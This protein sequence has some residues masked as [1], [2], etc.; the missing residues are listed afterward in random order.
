MKTIY[1][2]N[3]TLDG[4][5]EAV[6]VLPDYFEELNSDF[7]Y[8]FAPMGSSMPNLY[9]AE[10]VRNNRFKIGGGKPGGEVSWQV[11]GIRKDPYAKAHPIEVEVEK[12]PG[13][14]GKYQHPAEW[15]QPESKGIGYEEP[16]HIQEQ[17]EQLEQRDPVAT[18]KAAIP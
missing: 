16:Q 1:D 8:Q 5:G 9:I 12:S 10:K 14:K 7:R 18:P 11:T 6:V 2:G 4:K 17:K 13:E 15:G 3:V